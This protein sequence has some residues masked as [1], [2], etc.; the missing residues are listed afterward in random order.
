MVNFDYLY[1]KEFYKSYINKDFRLKKKLGCEILSNALVLPNDM[2]IVT[3]LG[4]G[5]GGGVV[6]SEGKFIH[7]S[8]MHPIT[9]DASYKPK[10]IR[11]SNETAIYLGMFRHVWGHV[12]TDN[13]KRLWF[14]KSDLY[15]KYFKG[16]KLIYIPMWDF[17]MEKQ[18]QDCKRLLEIFGLDVS[19]LYP[20]TEATQ[21]KNLIFPDMSFKFYSYYTEEYRET[22]D[23]IRNFAIKNYKPLPFKKAYFYHGGHIGG[24]G[25]IGEE[26]LAQYFQSKG[27][28]I[29]KGHELSSFDEEL[30]VLINLESFVCTL[31]SCAQNMIFLRDNTEVIYIPRGF[32][33]GGYPEAQNN[34][35]NVNVIYIDSSLSVCAHNDFPWGGPFFY[36]LSKNLLKYFGDTNGE[37]FKYSYD[38]F[39][40]FIIYLKE[41][42]KIGRGIAPKSMDYY[43]SVYNE[44][45]GQ[46]KQQE[47]LLK[48]EGVI[49][50]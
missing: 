50:N 26:R 27:Y 7:D 39:K 5:G 38:D 46:L 48:E 12:L 14:L 10:R 19:N 18:D 24:A 15:N 8:F 43:G 1:K 2:S 20:I 29:I 33:V 13:I 34:V 31:G 36:F 6:D 3:G 40:T 25:Q 16:A 35:H 49:I 9:Q 32:Y 42:V 4:W 23:V 41:S 28:A 21:Y 22:V 37:N 45:L 44:F 30:N 17:D 11:Y 47:S